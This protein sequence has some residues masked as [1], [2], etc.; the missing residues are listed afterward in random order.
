MPNIELVRQSV[1][2]EDAGRLSAETVR[3]Q[4]AAAAEAVEQMGVEVV[5]R[6]ARLEAA[7]L[8]ASSDMELIT[9]AAKVIKEKGS[10]VYALIDDASNLSKELRAMC[11]ALHKRVANAPSP[12]A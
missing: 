10:L 6:I 4:F 12:A 1:G 7:L 5:G 11:A 2:A 9:E 8:E 3:A